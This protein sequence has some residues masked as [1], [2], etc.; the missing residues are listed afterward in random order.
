M[1][2]QGS[3]DQ[4]LWVNWR[5]YH[6]L[7]ER[8]ALSIYDSGWEFDQ[9]LCLARGGLRVGDVLSRLFD[10][11]LAILSTSSYRGQGGTE[12]GELIISASISS[13]AGPLQGKVLVVDDLADSGATLTAVASHLRA[14]FSEVSEMRSAV[15]WWK[16]QSSFAP[17]FYVDK[18][19]TNSWIHQ[20]FERY[21]TLTPQDM[22]L[23]PEKE[24]EDP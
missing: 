19:L 21:D 5:E 17:D 1:S 12:Q 15:L 14:K 3:T 2:V 7:I 16:P 18:L 10:R 20:P 6:R 9:I 4:D 22:R 24:N 11:P 23:L 8:L 13:T